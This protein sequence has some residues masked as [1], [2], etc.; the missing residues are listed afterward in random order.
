MAIRSSE[1]YLRY[2]EGS[3]TNVALASNGLGGVCKSHAT[4]MLFCL[5]GNH[6]GYAE[7][8][9][10]GA[11]AVQAEYLCDFGAGPRHVHGSL[12]DSTL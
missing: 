4:K 8:M 7:S 11:N 9:W 1:G 5:V 12:M 10:N 6:E 2:H 3:R